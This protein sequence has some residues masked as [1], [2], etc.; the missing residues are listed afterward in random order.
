M[1]DQWTPESSNN[2]DHSRRC[3]ANHCAQKAAIADSDAEANR[4]LNENLVSAGHDLR[5]HLLGG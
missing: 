3:T 5:V 1:R 4:P 2:V